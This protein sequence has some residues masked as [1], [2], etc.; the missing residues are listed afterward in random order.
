M[1]SFGALWVDDCEIFDGGRRWKEAVRNSDCVSC[2][3]MM[4]G[5]C[6]YEDPLSPCYPWNPTP[7]P[8][9]PDNPVNRAPWYNPA[10]PTFH[11]FDVVSVEGLDSLGW[12]R[13]V[14]ESAS[15]GGFPGR[16]VPVP[17]E[18]IIEFWASACQECDLVYGIRWLHQKFKG[19]CGGSV[20]K[21]R[22]C[23]PDL[24]DPSKGLW[25]LER[26]AMV[27]L[28]E[29]ETAPGSCAMKKY[30]LIA[31]AGN[32]CLYGC[33]VP[34]CKLPITRPDCTDMG[35]RYFCGPIDEAAVCCTLPS[36][37]DQLGTTG[38][39]VEIQNN[40]AQCGPRLRVD[41]YSDQP[42][43]NWGCDRPNWD[44]PCA[45][46]TVDNIPPGGTFKI[47]GARREMLYK[48][49]VHGWAPGGA[50]YVVNE[51]T[52][53]VWPTIG[54]GGGSVRIVPMAMGCL[55]ESG[56]VAKVSTVEMV[57]C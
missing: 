45:S 55:P 56:L 50:F 18:I 15:N 36:T 39:V 46:F 1:T 8:T 16:S 40:S 42:G 52:K 5:E 11:G 32:P 27:G 7:M 20:A 28:E 44:G 51:Y 2:G 35:A 29:I 47:D 17:R 43:R 21:M 19:C 33:T 48:D 41:I 38:I 31:V 9:T 13:T 49:P 37:D 25:R 30:R 34:V 22:D 10:Y 3:Q 54:C 57:G 53:L 6:I 26:F 23:A 24:D 14:T 4:F 12:G